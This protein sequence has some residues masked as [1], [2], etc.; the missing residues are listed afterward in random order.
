MIL[1]AGAR[2][3]QVDD[4]GAGA[5]REQDRALWP[6]ICFLMLPARVFVNVPFWGRFGGEEGLSG[7][8]SRKRLWLRSARARRNG[9]R[10]IWLGMG[11]GSPEG[12]GLAIVR[13]EGAGCVESHP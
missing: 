5:R 11:L 4:V 12:L 3:D 1:G 9:W 6:A 8:S 13:L 10:V 7:L 2:R